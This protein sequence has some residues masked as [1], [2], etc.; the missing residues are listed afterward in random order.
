MIAQHPMTAAQI[1][2]GLAAAREIGPREYLL[3]KLASRY[4]MRA[5]ELASIRVSDLNLKDC[6]IKITPGK[7]SLSTVEGIADD[8]LEALKA[9]LV[10]KPESK[11]LFPGREPSTH[12][13]RLSVYNIFTSIAS[14]AGI[15]EISRAPHAWRHS[16]GQKLADSGVAIQTIAHVLRHRSI[17]STQHYFRVSQRLADETKAKHLGW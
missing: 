9:W 12:L 5:S 16:I 10:L 2:A 4:G 6:T 3:A 17:K 13:T 7:R 14:K 8:T 11:F 15:P 1:Q